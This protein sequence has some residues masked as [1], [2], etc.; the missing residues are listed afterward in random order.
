MNLKLDLA[1]AVKIVIE[2][3]ENHLLEYIIDNGEIKDVNIID[4][5]NSPAKEYEKVLY[6]DD[7]KPIDD[8]YFIDKGE[9]LAT[10]IVAARETVSKVK[11]AISDISD[12]NVL[13]EILD[14]GTSALTEPKKE[15]NEETETKPNSYGNKWYDQQKERNVRNLERSKKLM[16]LVKNGAIDTIVKEQNKKINA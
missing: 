14:D 3:D 13:H 1:K 4:V 8:R 10:K 12:T 9:E 15:E 16:E 11:D 7:V 6:V 2:K 5:D